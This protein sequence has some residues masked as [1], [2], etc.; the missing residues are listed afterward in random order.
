ML[1][2]NRDTEGRQ[3]SLKWTRIQ[4]ADHQP[5]HRDA[6]GEG[7]GKGHR[8]RD[9]DRQ[10]VVGDKLL[11]HIASVCAH[12]DE[13]TMGHVDDAHHAEGDRQAD[14]GEE[15]NRRQRN[16]VQRQV[17][18][19]VQADLQL[20]PLQCMRG[21]SGHVRRGL[22]VGIKE[23]MRSKCCINVG[24]RD[25][26]RDGSGLSQCLIRLRA[27]SGGAQLRNRNTPH[28]TSIDIGG[29]SG[30]IVVCRN[31]RCGQITG[32]QQIICHVAWQLF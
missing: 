24:L 18:G 3:Q 32:N 10:R 31:T 16:R 23:H 9:D 4:P 30:A 26:S 13:L 2:C 7:N 17:E 28:A 1:Q 22:R 11:H 12:H 21:G 5:L 19:L 27:G 6:H 25:Q 20:N 15:I 14:G 8:D 29:Q